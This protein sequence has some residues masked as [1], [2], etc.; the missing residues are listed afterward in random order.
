MSLYKDHVTSLAK[1]VTVNALQHNCTCSVLLDSLLHQRLSIPINQ[2]FS[3]VHE[4]LQ[5][6]STVSD[7]EKPKQSYDT[8]THAGSSSTTTTAANSSRAV[9][10]TV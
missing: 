8:Q 9:F 7:N 3:L 6:L 5:R 2:S 4:T 1:I 10:V